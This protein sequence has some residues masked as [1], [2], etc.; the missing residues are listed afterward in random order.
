[1]KKGTEV[2][3]LSLERNIKEWENKFVSSLNNQMK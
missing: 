3:S 2:I 1:M